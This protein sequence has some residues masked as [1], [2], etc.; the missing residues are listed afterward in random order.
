MFHLNNTI[1]LILAPFEKNDKIISITQGKLDSQA[2]Y[3]KELEATGK[4]PSETLYSSLEDLNTKFPFFLAVKTK[5]YI[6]I[7]GYDEDFRGLAYDDADF[8]ERLEESGFKYVQTEGRVVHLWHS[9]AEGD[10]QVDYNFKFRLNKTLY[11]AKK[12]L[13][14][15]N[16]G[17]PWGVLK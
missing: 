12:G 17:R 7:G 3:L 8:V 6:D 15:R 5:A 2:K 4:T 9:K 1:E 13:I 11:H 16:V 10:K 14:K